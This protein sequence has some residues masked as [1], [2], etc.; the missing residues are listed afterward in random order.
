MIALHEV[1]HQGRLGLLRCDLPETDFGIVV[2]ITVGHGNLDA[3]FAEFMQPEFQEILADAL[4]LNIC[5]HRDGG[6]D[7][8]CAIIL[9]Q[10][11]A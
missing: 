8:N 1:E 9:I 2:R 10:A 7:E 6:Q 11:Q 4:A 3:V 5:R